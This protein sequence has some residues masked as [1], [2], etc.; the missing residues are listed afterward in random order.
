MGVKFEGVMSHDGKWWAIGVPAL[1]V[2]SQGR[3]RPAAYRMIKEAVELSMAHPV[4]VEVLPMDGDRFVLRAKKSSDDR[5]LVAMMLRNHRA[6]SGLSL[7]QVAERLKVTRGTYAQYEQA[8]SLPSVAKIE[9]YIS[10]MGNGR[11]HV[12]LDVVSNRKSA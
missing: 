10:A 11:E 6:K 9:T 4:E 1:E 5:Y 3:T 7:A 2:W 8:R 12:V